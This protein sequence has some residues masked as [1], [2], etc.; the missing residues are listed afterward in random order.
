M[1]LKR[2]INP[3]A[4]AWV[5]IALF[6]LFLAARANMAEVTVCRE[7]VTEAFRDAYNGWELEGDETVFTFSGIDWSADSP[8]WTG[9]AMS[10]VGTGN[11]TVL[12]DGHAQFG[13]WDGEA[14]VVVEGNGATPICGSEYEG[15]A[16]SIPIL[17]ASSD[18]F[19]VEIDNGDGG[20][21]RVESNGEPVLLHYGESLIAG[22]SQSLKPDDYRAVP[23]ACY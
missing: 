14:Y 8:W 10:E 16:P 23:T 6:S 5:I 11:L 9:E 19:Y 1:F 4:A 18:C 15:D 12:A 3:L 7:E 17:N 2:L 22:R 21:S 20:W 13:H